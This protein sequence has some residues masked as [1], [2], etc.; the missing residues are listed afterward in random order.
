MASLSQRRPTQ[1]S[2]VVPTVECVG[3]VVL[4]D[5]QVFNTAVGHVTFTQMDELGHVDILEASECR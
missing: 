3:N 2:R 4:S 5:E 1:T